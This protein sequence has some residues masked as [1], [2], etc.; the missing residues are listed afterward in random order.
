[1]IEDA[2]HPPVVEFTCFMNATMRMCSLPVEVLRSNWMVQFPSYKL[3]SSP[4][5]TQLPSIFFE[6]D[7]DASDR[8]PGN[9]HGLNLL[10]LPPCFNGPSGNGFGDDLGP[11]QDVAVGKSGHILSF[12]STS[13]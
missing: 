13:Q 1:M 6:Y 7:D 2:L 8:T 4:F 11:V 10:W 12:Y 5:I 9:Q 3:W